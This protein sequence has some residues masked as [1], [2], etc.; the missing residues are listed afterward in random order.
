MREWQVGD[1]V[2]DG[3]DIGV[4][5][6]KYMNY[7]RNNDENIILNNSSSKD[8]KRSKQYQ[9]EALKLNE[10]NNFY[11]ALSFINVA[12]RYNPDD[13]SNWNVKGIILFNIYRTNDSNV[14]SEAYDAYNNALEIEPEDK[15]IKSNKAQLIIHWGIRLL[16]QNQYDKAMIKVKEAVSIID[17]KTSADYADALTLK[18]TIYMHMG[19]YDK[20]ME[21]YNN[22]LNIN[23]TD[24][25][26]QKLKQILIKRIIRN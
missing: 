17:D 18:A 7:L 13:S 16:S 9:E 11:D 8:I 21:Y 12:I 24:E 4:P 14:F 15:I 22:A 19:K 5:D 26:I 2:G 20:A 6:T 10:E 23:P 1:P 3:N 25:N